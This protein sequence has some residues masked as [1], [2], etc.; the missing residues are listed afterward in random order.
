MSKPHDPNQGVNTRMPHLMTDKFMQAEYY[1]PHEPRS[2]SK[3]YVETHKTLIFEKDMP[4][5]VCG[6]RNS[7]FKHDGKGKVTD[8]NP[9]GATE[10][11]THHNIIEWAAQNGINWDK[12]AK[13]YPNLKSLQHVARAWDL[14]R[15][16][17]HQ[18]PKSDEPVKEGQRVRHPAFKNVHYSTIDPT[19][20]VDGV[21]QMR[22]LCDV[23]H[24]HPYYGIHTITG[25]IWLLQ[26]YA[27]DGFSFIPPDIGEKMKTEKNQ[28]GNS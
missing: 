3:L 5:W 23:H 17:G 20:F 26:R 9:F 10:N 1:P 2:E 12:V 15:G 21:E 19:E 13:D 25:P 8:V 22:V 11:E 28:G 24:R 7:D 18:L 14:E 27:V 16:K 6:V 4:C